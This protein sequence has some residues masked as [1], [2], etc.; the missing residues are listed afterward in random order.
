VQVTVLLCALT[1][2]EL[3]RARANAPRTMKDL[4]SELK[5]GKSYD[6]LLETATTIEILAVGLRDA[7]E[8][9]SAEPGRR[10][11]RWRRRSTLGRS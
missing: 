3:D 7:D 9:K 2:F 4:S 11:S 5:D 1:Q 8:G 6:E 10:R